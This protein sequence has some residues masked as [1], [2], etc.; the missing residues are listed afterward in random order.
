MKEKKKNSIYLKYFL[1]IIAVV[2]VMALVNPPL[3]VQAQEFYTITMK[4]KTKST[5]KIKLAWEKNSKVKK[6]VIKKALIS[7]KGKRGALKKVKT[8][9][10]GKK[11]YVVSKLKKNR[12]YYFRVSGYVKKKGKYVLVCM[13]EAED[14]TGMAAPEWGDYPFEWS[15]STSHI[16]MEFYNYGGLPVKGYEVWRRKSGTKK[17]SKIKTIKTKKRAYTYK[18]TKVS[19]GASYDYKIRSVGKYKKKKIYSPFSEKL[20]K[21]ACYTTGKYTISLVSQSPTNFVIKVKSDPYNG[22]LKI[23]KN[24]ELYINNIPEGIDENEPN[25]KAE[26]AGW[27]K[28]GKTWK[29]GAAVINRGETVYLKINYKESKTL[30]QADL[31]E[32]ALL[33]QGEQSYVGINY[34]KTVA[35]LRFPLNGSGTTDLDTGYYH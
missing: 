2:A 8:L 21:S 22:S 12:S 35:S 26:L 27:G 4:T 3:D 5:S 14:R 9:K 24:A 13:G 15:Y 28:D 1:M 10:K 6:W 16:S 7:K 18:D 33:A 20:A 23:D 11:S 17:Y 19:K 30:T 31:A 34:N 29:S 25:D 32:S